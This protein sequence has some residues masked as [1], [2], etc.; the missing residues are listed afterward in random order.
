MDDTDIHFM[1]AFGFVALRQHQLELAIWL[2]GRVNTVFFSNSIEIQRNMQFSMALF[3]DV[4]LI[5]DDFFI[6]VFLQMDKMFQL[7]SAI[8][9]G[10]LSIDRRN[11]S[12]FMLATGLFRS[13]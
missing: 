8:K 10:P 11:A 4:K 7:V 1:N 9:S 6:R 12:W 13:I 2:F 5:F 3:V